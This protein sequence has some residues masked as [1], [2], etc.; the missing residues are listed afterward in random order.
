MK[1]LTAVV[2]G[3][4]MRA[5]VYT[6]YCLANKDKFEVVAVADPSDIC[7]DYARERHNLP[8]DKLYRSW[9]EL[10]AEPKMADFAIISTQDNLHLE[11]ALALIEKG[12]DILLEKPIAPTAEAC[13]AI[14]T[15]AEKR[16][17]KVLVCHVLRFTKFWRKLKNMI[18]SGEIGE[19]MSIIHMENVGNEHQSHSFVRGKWRNVAESSP[20][21]LA[22]CC[23]DTDILQWLIGKKCK[24]VQSFGSLTHFTPENKPEGA[25]DRCLDGCPYADTCYYNPIKLYIEDRRWDRRMAI[26]GMPEPTDEDVMNVLRTGP[27]GRCVYA[28]DNDAVDHQVV[29]ME[30]EGGCTVSFT[31]CAFNKLGRF[32]RIFGTKGEIVASMFGDISL[33]SFADKQIHNIPIDV[34]GEELFSGHGGGDEGIM[35]DMYEYFTGGNP[36]DAVSGIE[37][38]YLNHLICFA[39]EESRATDT[40]VDI[41]K[42]SDSL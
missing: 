25:P 26:T 29:N 18:D 17:V 12:Y 33:Y 13:K 30:F 6:D 7:L 23:H 35:E 42:F 20:M 36:S 39:A 38:S 27:Y 40:V 14:Y 3:Y 19:V 2:V 9:D 21:I 28:C 31:M 1:K 32:I 37:L 16:G 10:A 22:K 11:P 24:K 4:G 15:A 41:V 8:D 34:P 5:R